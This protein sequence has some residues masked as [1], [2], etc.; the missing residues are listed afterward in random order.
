MTNMTVMSRLFFCCLLFTETFINDERRLSEVTSRKSTF[1][2]FQNTKPYSIPCNPHVQYRLNFA[3]CLR[4]GRQ[5]IYR[6]KLM[7]TYGQVQWFSRFHGSTGTQE[8]SFKL[9]WSV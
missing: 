1:S 5:W 6:A 8:Q 9:S 7:H 2:L 4:F 3:Q